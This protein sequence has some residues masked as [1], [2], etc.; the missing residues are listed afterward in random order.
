MVMLMEHLTIEA[1]GLVCELDAGEGLRLATGRLFVAV[2]KCT[3]IRG[4][5]VLDAIAR[6]EACAEIFE[7]EAAHGER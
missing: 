6:L 5:P 4:L 1:P 2:L 7:A 3:R